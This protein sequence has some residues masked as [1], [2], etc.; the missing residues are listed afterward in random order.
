MNDIVFLARQLRV[1]LDSVRRREQDMAAVRGLA[2]S[3]CVAFALGLAMTSVEALSPMP[4]QVRTAMVFSWLAAVLGTA[5]YTVVPPVLRRF[6]LLG[7]YSTDVMALRVGRAF[8]DLGDMLCNVLQLQRT[9]PVGTPTDLSD[10]AFMTVAAVAADKDFTVI[11]DRRPV[12]RVL[13]WMVVSL[14]LYW[15]MVG[16]IPSMGAAMDR[17]DNYDRSYLPKAPFGF[18]IDPVRAT[19]MRGTSVTL[20]VTASGTPPATVTMWVRDAGSERFQ[21]FVIRRDSGNV[22]RYQAARLTASFAA[23]AEGA[24]LD[25][26][27]RSDTSFVTVIDR[28]LVRALSGRV[29]SPAYAGLA[30][31]D[32]TELSA[33]VTA[34]VGSTVDLTVTA[35]K[36]LR[37]ASI[38]LVP[39]GQDST[40]D[41]VVV[42][43][44]VRGR[45]ASGRF[46]VRTNAQYSIHMMDGDGQTNA[47][48]VSYGIVALRDGHPTIALLRPTSNVDI[49]PKGLLPVGVTIA[50]DFGFDGVGLYYRLV[51][52]R[53][54]APQTQFKR[55]AMPL[56]PGRPVQDV[57]YVW[58]L[59]KAG[60]SP[61]DV[62][63][64]YVEVAD[65]DRIGGPKTARTSTITVRLPSLDEVFAE[66]DRTHTEAAT[67]LK[68]LAREAEEVRRDAEQLQRELQKQQQQ[69]NAPNNRSDW[70][71]RKQ[72]EDL[73]KRQEQIAKKMDDVRQK[74]EDMTQQLQQNQA[75]SK[76]T[77]EKYQ[78]L[79]KL[80]QEVNSPE[81]R[82]MQEEM[83]KAME[84]MSPEELQEAMKNVK[85]DE[86][87][88]R[89]NVER[90]LNLMKR[91]QAEQK[92]DELAK[93]AED[94]AQRQEELRQQLENTSPQNK[95]ERDRLAKQQ[96]QLKKDLQSL[97]RE[98]KDLESLMKELGDMP[99]KDM[100][101]A[102][103]DLAEQQT[104]QSMDKASNEMQDGDMDKASQAQQQASNNLQRFA[105]Q[106]KNLKREMKKRGS[107]EAMRQMQKSMNDMLDLSR[108]QESL[109]DQTK[110]M[111]PSS[112]QYGEAARRQ[113]KLQEAMQNTA[114]SMMQL[115]QKS[116]SVTPEMAEDMGN[117]LQ[118]MR[119]A[120]Q[121][122][123][124]RQGQQAAQAQSGAMSS[125][126]SA[127][128]KM[129]ES[130]GR[131]MEGEGQGQGGQGQ[132]PGMG[133]GKGQSPFQRLQNLADQQQSINQGMQQMGQNGQ[134]MNEQQRAEMGRLASQQGKAMKALQELENEQRGMPTGSKKPIGDLAKIAEDMKEVMSDMQSGSITD[135]TRLRQERILSRL[136]DASRSV[137]D[138][139]YE[140]QRES[141][142][143]QDVTR[144][145]PGSLDAD[146]LQQRQIR[147][148][149]ELQRLRK[150]YTRDY[151]TLIRLYFEA[152][153]R[154]GAGGASPQ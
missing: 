134:P 132:N 18:R 17:L 142:S 9:H 83:R 68:E 111:D 108:Q 70:K 58:D 29:V 90:T 89:K 82:R 152:L 84:K 19:V 8:D 99:T 139:D 120:M 32:L 73:M 123:Q 1:R 101:Q 91:L 124:D 148:R 37:A 15:G 40:A 59:N 2:T 7:A 47:D 81:M 107:R 154:Q 110:Q 126:N 52:S 150:G 74:L 67:A 56:A 147:Q 23:Y 25:D 10:A 30:P 109:R 140:K 44:T 118:S 64:F 117:A 60:L 16:L 113:Q 36:D 4:T 51:K 144:R 122:L 151:E 116:M 133:E 121:G 41:T 95:A 137:N 3:V 72:A 31:V 92:T 50:D 33:D 130:L 43:L 87:Q 153:Q 28:P 143:G 104:Q 145:S 61:E 138:R 85:F 46:T 78:E 119:D 80:M 93:R 131:M 66:T 71:E 20:T 76:E 54:A 13:L 115:A 65:N 48:P 146:L 22:Y 21:P 94:L 135:E 6:G 45:Q 75:I 77:L 57:D 112:S 27:I 39:A 26:G 141:R 38:R 114:S 5:G 79:Q 106:M 96:E 97:A 55:L 128:Q 125:M 12:R 63:E 49:D 35:S 129:S 105:Q 69:P 103:E 100:E 14:A 136:L 88:F 42:P 11:I 149:E 86:E 62:Y 34:L 102:R 53:Y 24:W 98:S 127:I